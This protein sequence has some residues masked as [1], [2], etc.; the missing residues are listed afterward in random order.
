M[1][2]LSTHEWG[3]IRNQN[4]AAETESADRLPLPWREEEPRTFP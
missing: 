2:A 4:S 3:A 1:F